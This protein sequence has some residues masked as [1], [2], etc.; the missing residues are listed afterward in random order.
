MINMIFSK[1]VIP[2]AFIIS[3][4]RNEDERGF[5]ARTFCRSEFTEHGLNP[6]LVQCSISFNKQRGTLRGMHFQKPPYEETKVVRCTMGAMFDVIIDLRP[7]SP[8]FKQWLSFELNAENR[9]MLYI[10]PGLAHGFLTLEDNTEMLYQMSDR[11]VPESAAGVRWNDTA[12]GIKWPETPRIISVKDQE[13][14]DFIL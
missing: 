10:P 9:S 13:Y 5:F 14:T 4:N 11:Y 6:D 12:F 2:D 7:D 1:T 8:T 3:L